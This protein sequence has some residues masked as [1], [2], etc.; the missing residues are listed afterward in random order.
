VPAGNAELRA[1]SNA[2]AG[3]PFNAGAAPV[4]PENLICALNDW[5]C[6]V[7]TGPHASE[8]DILIPSP[9]ATLSPLEAARPPP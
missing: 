1:P 6:E 4:R 2:G 7:E 8:G 9:P 5:I 3:A